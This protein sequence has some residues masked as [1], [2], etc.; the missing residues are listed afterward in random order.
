MDLF[1]PPLS[2]L[3]A[4]AGFPVDLLGAGFVAAALAGAAALGVADDPAA[5]LRSP[6]QL[7]QKLL[8]SAFFVPHTPL[9]EKSIYSPQKAETAG[10]AAL[11]GAAAC[12]DKSFGEM[13]GIPSPQPMQNLPSLF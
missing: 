11:G 4:A 12:F 8:I 10:L 2:A 6:P 7:P 13:R 1:S 9:D 3:D 5:S